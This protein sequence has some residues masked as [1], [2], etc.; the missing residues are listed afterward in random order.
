[1]RRYYFILLLIFA[2]PLLMGMGTGSGNMSSRIPTP[3]KNYS[4]TITD[5]QGFTTK[6]SQ[7]SFDGKTF[8]GGYRGD[9]TV[10][11]PFDKIASVKV[12]KAGAEKR[13]SAEI[14]LKAGGTLKISVDGKLLC[15][16]SADFGNI[17]VEFRDIRKVVIDGVVAKENR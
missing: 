3:D 15:Y 7:V 17:Q 2:I 6:V 5:S 10:T 9:T 13:V 14:T 8:L 4:A 12:E 16:G 1:M 11:I